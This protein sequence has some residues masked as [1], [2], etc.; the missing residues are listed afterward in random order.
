MARADRSPELQRFVGEDGTS[1][2]VRR[3]V[4][5]G[6]YHVTADGTAIS[7]CTTLAKAVRII[8]DVAG[9]PP[10]QVF[11]VW[12]L[13]LPNPPLLGVVGN[14]PGR[15]RHAGHRMA[16]SVHEIR[17]THAEDGA[18]YRHE[19]ETDDV[20]MFAMPDGSISIRSRSGRRLW[21]DFD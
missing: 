15:R 18:N 9:V 13:D 12:G 5:N 3:C 17:Y 7:A 8:A 16:T 6:E 4:R 1:Y 11:R 2:R 10:E 14:P 21:D 19:F 20:Q